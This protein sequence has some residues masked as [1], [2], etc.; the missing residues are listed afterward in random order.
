MREECER[1]ILEMKGEEKRGMI[2]QL[3]KYKVLIPPINNYRRSRS[4][5]RE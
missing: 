1:R 5:I 4:E 2:I 3:W